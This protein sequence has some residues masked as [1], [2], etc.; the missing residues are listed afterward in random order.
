MH[1]LV[2]L[3]KFWLIKPISFAA[4]TFLGVVSS[5]WKE[6]MNNKEHVN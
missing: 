4:C 3:A 6:E 1:M 5:Y 2:F